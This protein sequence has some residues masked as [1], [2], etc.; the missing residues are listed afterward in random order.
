MYFTKNEDTSFN[1]VLRNK[2]NILNEFAIKLDGKYRENLFHHGV[3]NYVDYYTRSS[4]EGKDELYF[5]NFGLSTN[6]YSNQPNGAINLSQFNRVEL[7]VNLIVPPFS[8][9]AQIIEICDDNGVLIG[10]EKTNSNIHE[11]TF[12]LI[13]QEERYNLLVFTNGNASLTFT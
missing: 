2:K 11:Y 7:E 5:Y 1:L 4:G 3:Y 8:K 12:D 6:P 13:V 9:N 10:I